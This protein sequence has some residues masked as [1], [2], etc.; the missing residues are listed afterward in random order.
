MKNNSIN[1][2]SQKV[3][4]LMISKWHEEANL[5][6]K[7]IKWVKRSQLIALKILATIRANGWS[8]KQLAEKMGVSPQSVNKWVKGKE[9]FTLETISKLED[10]LEIELISKQNV[11]QHI[12]NVL[13]DKELGGNSVVKNFFTTAADGKGD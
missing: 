4:S 5:R 1:E 10:A 13:S 6:N 9:N 11:G 8:Q 2:K 12:A 7:N 3:V